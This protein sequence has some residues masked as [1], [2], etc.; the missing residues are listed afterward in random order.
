MNINEVYQLMDKFESSSLSELSF[1][2]D[3]AKLSLKKAS[4]IV[5]TTPVANAAASTLV[6]ETAETVSAVEIKTIKAP[7]VGTFYRAA[8]P[9]EIPFVEVGQQVKK[10]DVVAIIE[11]MKLMNEIT[12]TEDGIV[13]EILVEDGSLVEYSQVLIRMK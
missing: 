4:G 13:E 10:G 6:A 3:G 5:A 11:A 12:A 2:T 8:G 9:G 7:L 1:E